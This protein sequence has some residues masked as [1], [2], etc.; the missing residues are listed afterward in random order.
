M[1]SA[2]KSGT[3]TGAEGMGTTSA[4]A[5]PRK[6]RMPRHVSHCDK[7]SRGRS[8]QVYSASSFAGPIDRVEDVAGA[9]AR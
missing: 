6:V 5:A 4:V 9:A 7:V 3:A 2:K 8:R 1:S